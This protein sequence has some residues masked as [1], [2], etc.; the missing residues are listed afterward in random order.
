MTI[1]LLFALFV[2]FC[3]LPLKNFSCANT[4]MACLYFLTL[5]KCFDKRN[6]SPINK[7]KHKLV[8]L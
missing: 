3:V 1:I 7:N 5:I 4:F 6:L 8:I 2:I